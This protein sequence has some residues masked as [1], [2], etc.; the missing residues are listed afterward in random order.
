MIAVVAGVLCRDGRLMIY[1]RPEGKDM[2]GKWEFPGGK[3]EPGETPEQALVREWR[4]ELDMEVQPG[5]VLDVLRSGEGKDILLLFYS[6]MSAD[7]P[8]P[9]EGG[10]TVFITPAQA[11]EIDFAPMDRLF[12]ERNRLCWR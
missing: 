9:Q 1:Q 8:A 10:K 4:E 12:V 11:G 2:A 5:P 6:C 7:E 3:I